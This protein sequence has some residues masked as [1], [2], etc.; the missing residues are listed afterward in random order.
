MGREAPGCAERAEVCR[1]GGADSGGLVYVGVQVPLGG[2]QGAVSGVLA[3]DVD[4][5]AGAGVGE[6]GESGAPEVV[7]T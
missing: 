1:E 4:L 7:P 6:P 2:G 5:D 3:E